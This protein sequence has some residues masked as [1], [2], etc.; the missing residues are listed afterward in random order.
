MARQNRVS[1]CDGIY[2]V[3]ARIAHRAML[4]RDAAVKDKVVE[5]LLGAADFSGVELYAWCVM[6]NHLHLLVHVPRVPERYWLRPGE[7]PADG[8]LCQ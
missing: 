3:T 4:F 5:I 2:H 6:D 1:V 8:G 7:E